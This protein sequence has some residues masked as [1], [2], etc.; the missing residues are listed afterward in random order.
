LGSAGE[1]RDGAKLMSKAYEDLGSAMSLQ[2]GKVGAMGS[3]KARRDV[4]SFWLAELPVSGGGWRGT[5]VLHVKA[6]LSRHSP[7]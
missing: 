7:T 6:L 5:L 4:T 1:L 3:T 2:L